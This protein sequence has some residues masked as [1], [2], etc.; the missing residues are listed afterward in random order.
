MCA[1]GSCHGVTVESCWLRGNLRDERQLNSKVGSRSETRACALPHCEQRGPRTE[2]WAISWVKPGPMWSRQGDASAPVPR[3]FKR[4]AAVVG[5]CA[6]CDL[7]KLRF[8]AIFP[9]ET[10]RTEWRRCVLCES[11]VFARSGDSSLC[12][13]CIYGTW[14]G[15]SM[16]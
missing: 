14:Q 8:F 5:S 3:S 4:S 6:P 10:V 11:R 7:P 13:D 15:S 1:L 9:V 2:H 16:T 12:Y